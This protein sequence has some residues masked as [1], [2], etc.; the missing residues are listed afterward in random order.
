[1]VLVKITNDI[2]WAME[3][4]KILS[5]VCI[6]LSAAFDTV[7]HEILLQVL[8]HQYGITGTLCQWYKSY[9]RPRGFKVSIHDDYSDEIELPFPVTH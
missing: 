6:D 7:D 1:M 4:Q 8:P 5:L 2:L 9:I 3:H